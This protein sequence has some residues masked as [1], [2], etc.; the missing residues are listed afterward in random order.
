M[1]ELIWSF[2]PWLVFLPASRL[3]PLPAAACLAAAAA[4]AVL[5]RA[6]R[7]RHAHL[8]DVA[9]LCYFAVL[10]L[11]QTI[12]HPAHTEIWSRYAQ[13]GSH[14]V[15]TA[16]IFGSIL[17]GHPFTEPYAR[18]STPPELWHTRQ[19]RNANRRISA[20]W[21]L[22]FIIGDTSLALAGSA[23]SRQVLLRVI[24]P[25]GTL[26]LAY[27]YTQNQQAKT[28]APPQAASKP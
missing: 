11:A 12:A 20:I 27:R 3:L 23:S 5:A 21:G 15:L 19:F 26:Y 10:G 2:S 25:F 24:V 8:L 7:R 4:L 9:G 22:A 6:A 28:P 16:L 13:L 17:A 1:T 14:L 18:D